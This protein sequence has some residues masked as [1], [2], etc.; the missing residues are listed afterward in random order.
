M[1]RPADLARDLLA[2]DGLGKWLADQHDKHGL[3]PD[4][5]LA[6]MP[7]PLVWLM[8]Q[9]AGGETVKPG[10]SVD[11]LAALA[12][13]NHARGAKGLPPVLPPGFAPHI[14]RVPHG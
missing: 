12:R 3:T 8:L 9:P 6:A 1:R 2:W 7:V 4:H 11:K 5:F 13:S 10:R 14:P